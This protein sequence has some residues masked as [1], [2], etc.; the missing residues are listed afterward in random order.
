MDDKT[1]L[2]F[3]KLNVIRP[4]KNGQVRNVYNQDFDWLIEQAEKVE[5]LQDKV[6]RYEKALEKIAEDRSVAFWE[7]SSKVAK[8]ALE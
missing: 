2:E 1:R 6:E 5:S 8:E 7:L 4:K 3:V